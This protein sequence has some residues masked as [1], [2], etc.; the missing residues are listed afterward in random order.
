MG[1]QC[2]WNLWCNVFTWRSMGKHMSSRVLNILRPIQR[3]SWKAREQGITVQPGCNEGMYEPFCISEKF[4]VGQNSWNDRSRFLKY[5]LHQMLVDDQRWHPNSIPVK[6]EA[7]CNWQPNQCDRVASIVRISNSIQFS[8]N[9]A[10]SKFWFPL[11]THSEQLRAA[12]IKASGN[13]NEYHQNSDTQGHTS[14]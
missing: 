2:N 12:D 11:D 8:G 6:W 4:K 7:C 3:F 10:A 14:Y 13:V 5:V 9:Y 1:S